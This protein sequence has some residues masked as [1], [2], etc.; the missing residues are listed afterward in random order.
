MEKIP[1]PKTGLLR[2]WAAVF[3]SVSGLRFAILNESAFRQE[4]VLVVIVSIVLLFLPLTL[5]WKGLLLLAMVFVLVVELLNSAIES[6]VDIASPDYHVLAKRAKDM[7]S[8]AVFVS[9][10][11]AIV[12]WCIAVFSMVL[13]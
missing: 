9:I 5:I 3:Y 10:S 8:A 11:L 6:V 13:N 2:I 4:F 7:G 12:L 1:T